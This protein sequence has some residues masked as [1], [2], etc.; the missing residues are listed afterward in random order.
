MDVAIHH[1]LTLR[2]GG[3]GEWFVISLAKRLLERGHYVEIYALPL[4]L[5]A[6]RPL[7]PQV[8][9]EL[10][11][12][13]AWKVKVTGFDV[14]YYVYTFSLQKLHA[15]DAPKVAGIHSLVW[16]RTGAQSPL[17]QLSSSSAY[18]AWRLFCTRELSK[19]D[20]VHIYSSDLL[21]LSGLDKWVPPQRLFVIPQ[22]VDVNVFRPAC[23]KDE[24]FTVL[25][26]GRPSMYKGFRDYVKVA[27]RYRER[28]GGGVKFAY[29]GGAAGSK[30]VVPLGYVSDP[31]R[32]ACIY[33]RS[34]LLLM[35]QRV[36]TV[37]RAPLEAL[38][39]GTPV[40]IST[41]V[42]QEL[43][44]AG[45]IIEAY[46]VEAFVHVVNILKE[47]W[48]G[49]RRKYLELAERARRFVVDNLSLEATFSKME[50]M[51][52]KV[53]RGRRLRGT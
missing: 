39:C 13:E 44:G 22:G 35:P 24:E 31:E 28:Y 12:R 23:D 30:H 2:Y 19:Y 36:P 26:C 7:D 11:Y 29:V 53:S 3:G 51:L 32:L 49:D 14:A 15:N 41:S 20:A 18:V 48:D 42:P 17:L 8:L 10:P 34:H 40:A 1:H 52:C 45:A 47:L 6:P 50:R 5:G 21:K 25:Y 38:S 27:K 37:G 33:S 16:S 46:G 4:S 9:R 43:K